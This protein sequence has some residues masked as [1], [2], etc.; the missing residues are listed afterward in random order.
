[1]VGLLKSTLYFEFKFSNKAL[2]DELDARLLSQDDGSL[3]DYDEYDD[4]EDYNNK[5]AKY[6]R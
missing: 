5:N 2:K 3:D 4:Y 1:M 6:R